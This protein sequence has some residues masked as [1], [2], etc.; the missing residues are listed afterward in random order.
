MNCFREKLHNVGGA[1][2]KKI[3]SVGSI[4]GNCLRYVKVETWR[5]FLGEVVWFS[6]PAVKL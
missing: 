5:L 3:E 1:D 2:L 6:L 4:L